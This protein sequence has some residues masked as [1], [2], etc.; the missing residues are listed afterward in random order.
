VLRAFVSDMPMAAGCSSLA[1]SPPVD[2][3]VALKPISP[4]LARSLGKNPVLQGVEESGKFRIS[5]VI[6]S[7]QPPAPS[8][9]PMPLAINQLA[10]LHATIFGVEERVQQRRDDGRLTLQCAAGAKPAGVILRAPWYLP[11]ARLGLHISASGRGRFEITAADAALAMRESPLVLGRFDAGA[12]PGTKRFPLPDNGF[13]R[14]DWAFWAI[15]CPMEAGT[16]RIDALQIVP[17]PTA[18]PSRAT[19]V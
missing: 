11:R 3:I 13:T 2:E 18:V 7:V 16:L 17:Q 6:G 9:A 1:L 8:T 4:E 14:R 12:M 5:E 10:A 15:A 19:W